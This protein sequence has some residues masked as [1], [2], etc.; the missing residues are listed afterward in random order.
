VLDSSNEFTALW[1]KTFVENQPPGFELRFRVDWLPWVAK[2]HQRFKLGTTP[3]QVRRSYERVR[4]ALAASPV[5]VGDTV[6]DGQSLDNLIAGTLYNKRAFQQSADALSEMAQ[7][8]GL[9]RLD[10]RRAAAAAARYAPLFERANADNGRMP[11]A[12]DAEG[13]TF[14]GIVCNDHPT[15]YTRASLIK[16][17][18]ELGAKYPLRGWAT[19]GA[20]AC[21][22]WPRP[23]VTTARVTG[24]GLPP[25]LMV[26]A[27]RDPATPLAGAARAN[28]AT[29]G[30]RMLVVRHEG[31]HGLYASGNACVD[32]AVERFILTGTLPPVGATCDGQPIPPPVDAPAPPGSP[33]PITEDENPLERARQLSEALS[34]R[35]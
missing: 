33:T 25:M 13:A 5:D 10:R 30:T 24:K 6:V 20:W 4:A 12:P 9:Q 11:L 34:A 19:V 26:Q 7:A 1:Q 14:L 28:A 15:T 16:R 2:Y 8:F 35:H 18:A 22:F 27:A 3:Y 23:P 29:K 32:T 17:S 31:D 21:P